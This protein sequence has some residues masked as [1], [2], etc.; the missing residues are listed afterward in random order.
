[1]SDQEKKEALL[2]ELDEVEREMA[3]LK[4]RH[5]KLQE[6]VEELVAE[7]AR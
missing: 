6:A 7:M 3:L 5:R 1:M 2:R 4:D